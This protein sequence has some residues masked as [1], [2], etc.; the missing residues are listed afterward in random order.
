VASVRPAS[1]SVRRS[2]SL[3]GS[4][5][6]ADLDFL[7]IGRDFNSNGADYSATL[8]FSNLGVYLDY[9]PAGS[10]RLTGGVLL[11]NRKLEGRGVT[12]GGSV[13]INGTAYPAPAGESLT[14]TDRFPN[15]APY[16][17]V[18]FGHTQVTRGLAFYVDAGAAFGKSDVSLMSTPGI[19]AAAGQAN[20]DAERAKVQD[21]LDP[22]RVYPV[23]KLGVS[24]TY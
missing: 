11:G 18:G 15:A 14:V 9:F 2:S 10:F 20:I 13:T 5:C 12:T 17:G 16:L 19:L 7:S 3:P 8:K 23:V 21:K 6:R 22:L 1:N 4:A 24:Y